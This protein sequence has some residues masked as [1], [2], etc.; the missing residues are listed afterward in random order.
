V[1]SDATH[2]D[3]DAHWDEY[4]DAA[5]RNPAQ[6]Y[7]RREV[8]RLLADG[9]PPTRV[10]DIGSG[11]GELIDEILERW[12]SASALGLELSES[13]VA[14]SQ[15]RVPRATFRVCDLLAAPE[16]R[17]DEASWA[18]AAVC[19]EVLEHVDDP[20]QLLRN[21][22]AWFAPGCRVVVTVPGG[23]MST[24]DK[25][26]GHRRHFSPAE[27]GEVIEAAG[28]TPVTL[29]AAGFPFH[30]LYRSMVIGLGDRLVSTA[31]ADASESRGESPLVRAGS[32]VFAPLYRL[33]LPSSRFGWQTV[34]VAVEPS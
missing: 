6:A 7:R 31:R 25:H 20:I 34:A 29:N 19:S 8:L 1:T 24:F 2:D 32:A 4:A 28:L 9:A 22:R 3:W 21:A 16:P 17:Q 18:T 30:N 10:L 27:I 12:P 23:P 15:R 26:I 13:G 5:A 33:N 14:L 11:T